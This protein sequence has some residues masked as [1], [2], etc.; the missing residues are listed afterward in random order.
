MAISPFSLNHD[1]WT[2]F[3]IKDQD[4]EF[5]YN[6]LLEVEE[7]QTV[8]QLVH[9]LVNERIRRERERLEKQQLSGGLVYYPKDNYQVGQTIQFPAMDWKTGEVVSVRPGQN[10]EIP[11][12][13]V[14]EV[15]FAQGEKHEFAT[16]L[17]NHVLNQPVLINSNDPLLDADY[18]IKTFGEQLNNNLTEALESS[19]D[20]VRIGWKWFPRALLVDINVGHLNLAE[21]VLDMMG[22]GPLPTRDLME[23]ID[24][25]ADVDANLNEFSLNLAMQEDKRF[26]EVGPAGEVLWFLHRLEPE[27]VREVPPYLRFSGPVPSTPEV[28]EM[29]KQFEPQILDELQPDLNAPSGEPIEEAVISLIYPHWRAGTLPLAGN[30]TTLFPT[31]FES[32]RIQFTFVDG[33]TGEKFGGW[34]VRGNHYVYGLRDWYLSQGLITGSLIH[35][36]QGKNPGEVII[37]VD[38]KRGSREWIRTVMVGSDGGVVFSMLKHNITAA[39]DERMAIVVSDVD[40]L[41]QV[42][43][44]NIKQRPAYAQIVKLVMTEMAKLSTQGQVHSEELYAGVNIL[45]RCPPGSILSLL[46]ES[47]WAENLGNLYF[48]L[49]EMTGEADE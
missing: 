8:Q 16:G 39:I 29:L 1:Y 17:E 41:D 46:L 47:P 6:Y 7:P 10:P 40:M 5:L 15:Q 26:D 9:A 14:M 27:P 33:N 18:V 35:V 42:W 11:S 19:P 4:L 36:Q 37:R 49:N 20:L 21:A 30:L 34:V 44:R 28:Q 31:A 43:E 12:F 23:Q 22:G 38:K 3:E 45:R 13:N 48:R 2:N 24:L 25:P 32:P